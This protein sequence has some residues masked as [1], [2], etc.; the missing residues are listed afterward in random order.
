MFESEP[1]RPYE[2]KNGEKNFRDTR[3]SPGGE[4]GVS[5]W[6]TKCKIKHEICHEEVKCTDCSVYVE[7]LNEQK[8]GESK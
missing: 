8:R 6:Y 7:R 1:Y 5:A 3:I 4:W 2:I